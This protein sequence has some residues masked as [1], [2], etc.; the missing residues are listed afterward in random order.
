VDDHQNKIEGKTPKLR[1]EK[2]WLGC[3]IWMIKFLNGKKGREGGGG[4]GY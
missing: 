2:S 1:G 3:T 4:N